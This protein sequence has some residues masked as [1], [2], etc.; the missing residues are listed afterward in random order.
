[1]LSHRLPCESAFPAFFGHRGLQCLP[2]TS[3]VA[4][5]RAVRLLAAT[6]K[7]VECELRLHDFFGLL[8]VCT[9]PAL[10]GSVAPVAATD[11]ERAGRHVSPVTKELFVMARLFGTEFTVDASWHVPGPAAVAHAQA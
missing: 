8:Q 3:T 6:A 5:F 11:R 7:L 4:V 9:Q 2:G 1:M 10:V